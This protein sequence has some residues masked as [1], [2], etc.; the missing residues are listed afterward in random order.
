MPAQLRRGPSSR[1][2]SSGLQ[3]PARLPRR[4]RAAADRLAI[5][6]STSSVADQG[7]RQSP[8]APTRRLNRWRRGSPAG[9]RPMPARCRS[10][11]QLLNST[12]CRSNTALF[13]ASDL[14]TG[15]MEFNHSYASAVD[16]NQFQFATYLSSP[17]AARPLGSG[18]SSR[19][20]HTRAALPRGFRGVGERGPPAAQ[21]R[22]VRAGLSRVPG[23]Y[24][25]AL[26]R[27]RGP[28]QRGAGFAAQGPGASATTTPWRSG[29]A[30]CK[31]CNGPSDLGRGPVAP[32]RR[33]GAL[34]LRGR[35]DAHWPRLRQRR[36]DRRSFRCA[37][38]VRVFRDA[39]GRAGRRGCR[40]RQRPVSRPGKDGTSRSSSTASSHPHRP[41]PR[42]H[43]RRAPCRA[44]GAHRH[45]AAPRWPLHVA[46]SVR[47]AC[48]FGIEM[49]SAWLAQTRRAPDLRLC[50]C[51]CS[52]VGVFIGVLGGRLD[53]A[54]TPAVRPGAPRA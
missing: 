28:R 38:H 36:G 41:H 5:R 27:H 39:A 11:A 29:N 26:C 23:L 3:P 4:D 42:S 19:K 49:L 21:G 45:G 2:A 50:A 43:P 9:R 17:G 40:Q 1:R 33:G 53:A 18:S 31:R 48:G 10:R 16:L 32:P 52:T 22:V 24:D 37:D 6:R 30:F 51:P 13:V 15:L 54:D 35:R 44:P 47:R 25:V 8:S 34:C 20:S 46:R 12:S 7:F 14:I